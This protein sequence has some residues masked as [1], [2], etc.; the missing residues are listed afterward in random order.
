M[1]PVGL[2]VQ[3]RRRDGLGTAPT[4]VGLAGA[5]LEVSGRGDQPGQGGGRRPGSA[6]AN[7]VADAK[8]FGL[9]PG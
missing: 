5:V 7:S 8:L 1:A 2:L 4:Y 6:G 3:V 9:A